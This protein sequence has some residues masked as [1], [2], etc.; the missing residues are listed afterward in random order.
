MNDQRSRQPGRHSYVSPLPYLGLMPDDPDP[1]LAAV[2]LL[3]ASGVEAHPTGD[4]HETW[5]IG[6]FVM[7]DADVLRLAE[8][9]EHAIASNENEPSSVKVSTLSDIEK[10]FVEVLT[11]DFMSTS[12]VRAR[13]RIRNGLN[14]TSSEVLMSRFRSLMDW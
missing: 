7:T 9:F 1:I 14:P 8:R 3:R 2:T 12:V 5:M 4:D 13:V 11:D 6:D 10:D